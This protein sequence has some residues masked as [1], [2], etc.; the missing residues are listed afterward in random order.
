ML[1]PLL[2]LVLAAPAP[3]PPTQPPK[4]PAPIV[5]ICKADK[6][7]RP[8]L[9]AFVTHLRLKSK[10][11]PVLKD[12]KVVDVVHNVAD[13]VTEQKQVY[14]DEAGV[15]VYGADGKKVDPKILRNWAGYTPL[16]L[17]VDGKEVDPFYLPLARR[18]TLIVVSQVLAGD[19]IEDAFAPKRVP[20]ALPEMSREDK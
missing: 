5:L 10:T 1:L 13:Y 6:D 20:E 17:S 9:Q 4:G 7:G 15:A 3:E 19:R 14:L 12:G 16:L 8:F 2:S 18:G 11:V